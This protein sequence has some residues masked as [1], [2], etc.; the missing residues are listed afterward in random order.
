MQKSYHIAE[1]VILVGLIHCS[2]DTGLAVGFIHITFYPI[3]SPASAALLQNSL[4]LVEIPVLWILSCQ[5][6]T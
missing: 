2:L 6:T 3:R 4:W 1:Q 5:T